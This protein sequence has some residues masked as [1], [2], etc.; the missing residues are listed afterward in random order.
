MVELAVAFQSRSFIYLV[1][2]SQKQYRSSGTPLNLSG[3]LQLFIAL[4]LQLRWFLHL[5]A[6]PV[7][8]SC[9]NCLHSMM[10]SHLTT[11]SPFNPSFQ[12]ELRFEMEFPF[13]ALPSQGKVV[14]IQ[15]V[16]DSKLHP[17]YGAYYQEKIGKAVK[18]VQL[19]K[20]TVGWLQDQLFITFES[21]R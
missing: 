11:P 8:G 3:H 12:E 9:L 14:F 4:T 15:G 16:S 6:L 17:K 19:W 13:S 20:R 21:L 5:A 2:C 18:K 1:L 10:I 7:W